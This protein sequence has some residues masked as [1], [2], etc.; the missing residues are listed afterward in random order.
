[1]GVYGPNG[2]FLGYLT[3]EEIK[4]GM[5]LASEALSR[6]EAE[7]VD[8][9]AGEAAD[10][11]SLEAHRATG[12]H[13]TAQP[14]AVHALV[15]AIG[16][17]D[18]LAPL[19]IGAETPNGA[20]AKVDAETAARI[21]ADALL[22]SRAE[23]G[24][25]NG[26]A[27]LN[28]AGKLLDSALPALAINDTFPVDSQAAMLALVAQRGDVA[29]RS[30]VT[31]NFILAGD[32]PAILANWRELA[33]PADLVTSVQGLAGIVVLPSD[34]AMGTA[35]LRT[36]GAGAQQ[37][38]PGNHAS[39]TDQRIPPDGSVT[40]AKVAAALK[41]PAAN[42]AGLRTLGVGA[43]QAAAGDRI[44]PGQI[45][46]S[47]AYA[48]ATLATYTIAS[49]TPAAVDTAN[50]SVSF[51]VPASGAVVVTFAARVYANNGYPGFSLL[52]NGVH[53]PG[54]YAGSLLHTT[55]FGRPVAVLRIGGLT[56]GQAK[57]WAW[58][59][60]TTGTGATMYAHDAATVGQALMLV[61][62]A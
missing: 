32:D 37:A 42:V 54:S 1:V 35:S 6:V 30:D 51:T 58:A 60:Y 44:Y 61:E 48:P 16:G 29:I 53:V 46:G 45:I 59:W 43:G 40:G 11:A 52:D 39:T 3:A 41:D 25:P 13:A 12:A 33:I 23:K 56:P 18:L 27:E 31:R 8:R 7:I 62:A 20:Q 2:P 5:A 34:G 10:V 22:Q 26:Y 47:V 57:T 4:R 19:A 17:P 24:Q 21:A 28:A 49:A 50:L 9:Q 14:P 55:L 36:L 15:H 38:L